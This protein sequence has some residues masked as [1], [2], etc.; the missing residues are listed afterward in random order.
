MKGRNLT[1]WHTGH[2]SLTPEETGLSSFVDEASLLS[3]DF[4]AECVFMCSSRRSCCLK[5]I[6]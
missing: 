3:S 6:G 1:F 5:I 4:A 2:V